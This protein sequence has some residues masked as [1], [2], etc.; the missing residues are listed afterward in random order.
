[1]AAHRRFLQRAEAEPR[2][3]MVHPSERILRT[4]PETFEAVRPRRL[5]VA[6]D[7]GV[8]FFGWVSS[9]VFAIAFSK[10]SANNFSKFVE[11]CDLV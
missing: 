7:G 10:S 3:A 8:N 2:G 1:M 9:D 5:P 11:S 4:R 6:Q